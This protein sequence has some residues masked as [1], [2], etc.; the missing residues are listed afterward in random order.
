MLQCRT[1]LLFTAVAILLSA[2]PGPVRADDGTLEQFN[3]AMHD[4]NQKYYT[5]TESGTNQFL[6]DTIPEGVRRGMSNFFAN[7]GEPVVAVS[8]L[9][10][11][12]MDN[13]GIA[14]KRFFYNLVY[15]Y[16]GVVDRATEAGV[17]AERRDMGQAI[18]SMGLPD[19][20]FVVLP[21]YGPSTVGDFVGSVLPVL[22]GYA[23]LGEVFW[24]YR[25]SSKVASTM[26]DK[27]GEG[28]DAAADHPESAEP[29]K[30][31]RDDKAQYL[32]A[33]AI[34]CRKHLFDVPPAA[35]DT[36]LAPAPATDGD[37]QLASVPR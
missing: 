11:G 1:A 12:D 29:E 25:A 13:A 5:S 33:R 16:G 20:P 21:F 7:M 28:K 31:Y 22:A 26:A 17:K 19:G 36:A 37:P 27:D 15:G 23:A 2:R 30:A 6:S 35:Q 9:A 4:F 8:S 34:A 3:R 14:T 10:Q 24:V 32:A 18:C